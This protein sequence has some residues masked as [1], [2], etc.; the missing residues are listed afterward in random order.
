ML[1]IE[2]QGHL[3]NCPIWY[4]AFH[5]PRKKQ[6][7]M[8]YYSDKILNTDRVQFFFFLTNM[9]NYIS[10]LSKGL[11]MVQKWWPKNNNKNEEYRTK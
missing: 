4:K 5:C 8:C 6:R 11:F 9:G 1:V 3:S 7:D 2:L 10:I